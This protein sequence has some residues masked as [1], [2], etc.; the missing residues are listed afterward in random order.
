M[1]EEAQGWGKK[2]RASL[3]ELGQLCLPGPLPTPQP[4]ARMFSGGVPG[5]H[6]PLR[7]TPVLEEMPSQRQCD[8]L[9]QGV[10][11]TSGHMDLPKAAHTRCVIKSVASRAGV[12][13]VQPGMTVCWHR[14]VLPRCW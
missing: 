8:L 6:R 3:L 7:I 4:V 1:A 14:W 13:R 5:L 2:L 12:W 11:I 10:H 9:R